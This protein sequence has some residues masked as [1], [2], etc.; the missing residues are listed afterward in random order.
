VRQDQLESV[1]PLHKLFEE[2]A[3]FAQRTLEQRLTVL[4][5]QIEDDERGRDLAG[6]HLDLQGGARM[7]T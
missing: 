1:R 5:K 7:L 3:A 4:V 6:H 2:L